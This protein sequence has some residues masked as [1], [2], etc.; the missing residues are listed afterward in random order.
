VSTPA[1]ACALGL[2][3]TLLAAASGEPVPAQRTPRSGVV[4]GMHLN[5]TALWASRDGRGVG[6]ADTGLGGEFDELGV[7]PPDERVRCGATSLRF[8][9]G[10]SWWPSV[11]RRV[12]EPQGRSLPER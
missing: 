2:A 1:R 5:T 10:L 9:V 7:L 6:G 4:L 3:V 8:R 11:A 12:S